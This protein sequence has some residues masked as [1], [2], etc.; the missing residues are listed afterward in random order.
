MTPP[1]TTG[2]AASN[3]STDTL[4]IRLTAEVREELAHQLKVHPRLSAVTLPFSPVFRPDVSVRPTAIQRLMIEWRTRLKERNE[5][6]RES[7]E[8]QGREAEIKRFPLAGWGFEPN[9]GAVMS[10]EACLKSLSLEL[11]LLEQENS[12]EKAFQPEAMAAAQPSE[13]RPTLSEEL[14]TAVEVAKRLGVSRQRVYE[15]I[16]RGSIEAVK[17][18]RQRRVRFATL[19]QFIRRGGRGLDS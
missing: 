10:A 14:L 7:L 9:F 19:D 18:G 13:N 15:L 17:I 3:A 1:K 4:L 5:L 16:R 6:L 8:L 11:K 2:L 12:A